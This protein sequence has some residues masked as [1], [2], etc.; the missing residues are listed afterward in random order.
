MEDRLAEFAG[1]V[2]TALSNTESRA[3]LVRLAEEQAALRRVAT[4]VAR[5]T[6][7]EEVFAAVANEVAR[8]LSVDVAN[9]IRY[10]SDD[11]VTLMASAGNRIPVGSRWPL[12]GTTLAP[13]VLRTGRPARVDNYADVTGELAEDLRGQ[14]IRSSVA[15]PII[16]EGR[17]WGQ[18]VTSSSRE[19]PLPPDT[20]ARLAS[21]TALVGMAIANTEARMEV[22]RLVDE[23]AAL[24][25]VATLVAEGAGPIAVFDAVAAEVER[26]LDAH[27]VVL[28]RYESGPEVTVVAHRGA[29]A[30]RLG[31]GTRLSHEG[32]NV[33]ALVRRSERPARMAHSETAQ[34]AIAD[35]ARALSVG[36]SVGAPVVVEGLLWGVIQAGWGGEESPPG[37]TEERMVRFAELLET[38]IANADSRD[39]LN[40]SRARLLTEGD[41]ARRRVVRDLHDGAQQRLVHTIITLK[42]ANRALHQKQA[43]MAESLLGEALEHAEQGHTE[44]RELAHGLLPASLKDGLRAGVDAIAARHDLS[45]EV[46]VPAQRFPMEIERSAYFIVAESLTN[47]VKH[48]HARHAKVKAFVD[49]GVLHVE[50]R[51][52]GI[53][54][55]DPHGHGLIGLRDRATALGGRLTIENPARGGTVVA[56]T[57]PLSESP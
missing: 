14:R 3:G 13:I 57:L 20:E 1:L 53:G 48:A 36:V 42:L 8:L 16:V 19:Q 33:A 38:A 34:G 21:F 52:D 15:T 47:I 55:A 49:E 44:L 40:A 9:V 28:G 37:D 7:P 17:V 10:E 6:R 12:S 50:V 35:I 4:L 26:L 39:Q 32:E 2:A 5:G 29:G 25:R 46:D 27:E 23:Q 18:M 43:E 54:G 30:G 45:V 22:A 31:R 51:D 24:R 11:T 41:E 56:A